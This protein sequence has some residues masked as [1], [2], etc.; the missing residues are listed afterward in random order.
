V[1]GAL[2]GLKERSVVEEETITQLLD[3]LKDTSDGYVTDGASLDT[4]EYTQFW[5]TNRDK[6]VS[7]DNV[8]GKL[9]V[10]VSLGSFAHLLVSISLLWLS[11]LPCDEMFGQPVSYLVASPKYKC[12]Y[13]KMYMC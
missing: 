1:K 6:M 10:T 13:V 4:L 3:R 5:I 11:R 2:E 7:K 12:I 8:L 9:K